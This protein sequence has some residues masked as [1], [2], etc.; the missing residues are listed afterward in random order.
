M[1][2]NSMLRLFLAL[3]VLASAMRLGAEPAD[4]LSVQITPELGARITVEPVEVT[5]IH[6]S[7][8]LPGRVA[9]DEHRLARIGPSIS[10]RVVEIRVFVGRNVRKGDVLAV[11]NSTELS[12]TQAAYL[13]AKT[14][15]G[16]QRLAVDRARRLFNEGIISE[17]TLKEREGGLA[18]AEVEVR[19]M[20][21]QLGIM[22]MSDQAIL[23]LMNTGQ[24]NSVTPVTATLSGTVIERHIS[25]GQIAEISDEL[26][27]VADLSRVWAVA[28]APEQDAHMAQIGSRV[29][30]H[31]PALPKEQFTGK[32]V[33]VGDTVNPETRTVTLRME[34]ENTHHRIKPGM[35]VDMVIKQAAESAPTIPAQAVLREADRDHVFVALG[36]DR[37]ALRPVTLDADREGRRRVLEGLTTGDRI[38]VEG[39]FHLNNV[40]KLKEL[41]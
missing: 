30:V 23:K 13:K 35:L 7:V 40:R 41:E 36:K 26:F 1:A 21:D 22:G 32:I 10:G 39:A 18:E 2:S 24:I 16:L 34:V 20:A 8:R 33:F 28:E 15:M 6:D 4:E 11:L 25:V 29:E 3:L 17:A 9:L 37:F 14:Q 38:V 19:A 5:H 27:T 12:N 31:I